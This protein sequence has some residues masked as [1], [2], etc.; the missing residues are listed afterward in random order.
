MLGPP[1]SL[2]GRNEEPALGSFMI[3][4]LAIVALAAAVGWYRAREDEFGDPLPSLGEFVAGYVAAR[5]GLGIPPRMLGWL[6]LVPRESGSRR[7]V[8]P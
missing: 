6:N 2:L 1:R 4:L 5:G 8:E 3:F 7:A